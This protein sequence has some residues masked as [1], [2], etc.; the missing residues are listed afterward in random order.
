VKGL[1]TL[2]R[3][4]AYCMNSFALSDSIIDSPLSAF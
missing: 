2:S 4:N 3:K 1:E